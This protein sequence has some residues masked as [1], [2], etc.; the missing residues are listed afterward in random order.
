MIEYIKGILVHKTP[1]NVTIETAMGLAFDVK[2]PVST[3]EKLPAA[4]HECLLLTHLH[5]SQE[6]IRLF[7]F[8]EPGERELFRLL[9]RIGGIGPKIALSIL[10]SLPVA[11][12]VRAIE[13]GDEAPITKVPGIGKKSAQRL[14]VE[15]KGNLLHLTEHFGEKDR[16]VQKDTISEVEEALLSLGFNAKDV[17]RELSLLPPEARDQAPELLIKDT[18]RRIYQRSR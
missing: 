14:I 13:H 5:I 2:I 7:G 16:I 4:G 1:V 11:T 10:S 9:N 15:L 12:F 8:I 6:D 3:F 18:I 17:A